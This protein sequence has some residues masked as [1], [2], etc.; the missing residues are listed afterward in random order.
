VL[1]LRGQANYRHALSGALLVSIISSPIAAGPAPSLVSVED[2]VAYAVGQLCVPYALDNVDQ[3]TLPIGRGLVQP[4]GQDG[5]ARPN[6]T[7]VR[8]GEAGFVHVTFSRGAD[9]SRACDVEA[10]AADPQ[11]LRQAALGALARRPEKFVPTKSRY[12]PGRFATEDMLCASPGAPHPAAFV[13]LSS[14]HPEESERIAILFTLMGGATRDEACDHAGVQ[15]NYR[16]LA[17]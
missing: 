7:G 17:Q 8:V 5:L 1:L 2:N 9:G 3:A 16:T 14:P 13:M 10:K 12:F 15:K 11:V 6:P 4:D